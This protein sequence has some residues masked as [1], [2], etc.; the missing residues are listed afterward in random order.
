MTFSF[1]LFSSSVVVLYVSCANE[2]F[3]FQSP[4]KPLPGPLVLTQKIKWDVIYPRT[5]TKNRLGPLFIKQM[6][7]H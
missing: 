1:L 5:L 6:L 2:E 4:G 7:S 3:F